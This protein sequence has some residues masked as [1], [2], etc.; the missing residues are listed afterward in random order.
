MTAQ[1]PDT[2]TYDGK[3]YN[4]VAMSSHIGFNPKDYGLEP[5]ASSTACWRGYWCEYAI[6]NGRLVLERLFLFN[7]DDNYPDF[8]GIS[9]LPQEYEECECWTPGENDVHVESVPKYLGHRVY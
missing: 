4:I 7:A 6:K 1:I 3:E 8:N 2:Y 5:Q 9:V